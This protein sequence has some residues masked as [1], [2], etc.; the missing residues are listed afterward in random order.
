MHPQK[1]LKGS[2]REHDEI[3]QSIPPRQWGAPLERIE[4]GANNAGEFCQ[5]VLDGDGRRTY[6]RIA[7]YHDTVVLKTSKRLPAIVSRVVVTIYGCKSYE[8]SMMKRASI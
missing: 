7:R 2:T 5:I 6:T 3:T 4:T 1:Y 8:E